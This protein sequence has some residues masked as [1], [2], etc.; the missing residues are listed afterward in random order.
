VAPTR[1][2][3]VWDKL[4]LLPQYVCVYTATMIP[5]LRQKETT[6]TLYY[7]I[8]NANIIC[9]PLLGSLFYVHNLRTWVGP[10][11]EKW[12]D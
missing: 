8:D 6:P 3:V 9:I 5:G 11:F 1:L 12:T 2:E 4:T 10:L 7:L